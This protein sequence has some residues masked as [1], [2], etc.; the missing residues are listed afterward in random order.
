MPRTQKRSADTKQLEKP[1]DCFV[2]IRKEDVDAEKRSV[3]VSFSSEEPIRDY[4]WGPPVV[5]LHTKSAF[6]GKRFEEVGSVL[7]NHDIDR[8]VG[9][10]VNVT[11]DDEKHRAVADIVFDKD[12]ESEAA[13]QKVLSGSLRGV[14]VRYRARETLRLEDKQ[15]WPVPGASRS[16][17]GPAIVVRKWTPLE[18]SLTPIP[19][20]DTVGVGREV[21]ED[22]MPEWLKK[23]LVERGLVKDTDSEEAMQAAAERYLKE[24]AATKPAEKPA[25]TAPATPPVEPARTAVATTPSPAEL[26]R[27]RQEEKTRVTMLK[28]L[29]RRAGMEDK[30]D[31][32]IDKD[33]SLATAEREVFNGLLQRQAPLG[34]VEVVAEAR[35]K[36][37]DAFTHAFIRRAH[38]AL[39]LAERSGNGAQPW[40]DKLCSDI[41]LDISL[42][43]A[44]RQCLV[45]AGHSNVRSLAIPQLVDYAINQRALAHG[46]SD[47]PYLLENV[48]N[49]NLHQ[50]FEGAGVTWNAWC[51]V[52][53]VKDFKQASRVKLSEAGDYVANGELVPIEETSVSDKKETYQVSTYA[54]R[55]GIS[56][57]AIINDDLD[58]MS[59]TPQ[60]FGAAAARTLNKTIYSLLNSNPNTGEDGVAVFHTATHG[61]LASAG[62]VPSE[63]TISAGRAAMR[64]QKNIQGKEV[65]NIVPRYIISPTT[66]ETTIDKLLAQLVPAQTSNVVPM[67]IRNLTPVIDPYLD[68]Y[69]ANAWYLAAAAGSIDTLAA[70]F[71]NGIQ[72]P[73]ILR[74]DGTAVLG[75]EWVSYFDFGAKILEHRGLYKNP[76]A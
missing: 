47:F 42:G 71:L 52:V 30:V 38:R 7:I 63:T 3:R 60:L 69:N 70:V 25:E 11:L 28:D 62:A 64:L 56:R 68:G 15:S 8:I 33:Y 32:W 72:K 76:G 37:R 39:P 74:L 57:Q 51:Q 12:P 4:P 75:V 73:Q 21:K 23:A 40:D 22:L 34:R 67:W 53:S 9:R 19:A 35:D 16:I 45:Q 10:P 66:H 24:T 14:S 17:V 27:G 55:F 26:E 65:L 54:V 58:G 20:D 6:Q 41:P 5:L 61:N 18:F 46:T 43:E 29:A 50:G 48:A 1:I 44:L 31:T 59:R 49:K 36:F 13:F 2:A